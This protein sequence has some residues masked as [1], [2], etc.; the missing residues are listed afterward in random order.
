MQNATSS[1]M[2]FTVDECVLR[3]ETFVLNIHFLL[4]TSL[5]VVYCITRNA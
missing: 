5:V 4:N 2:R 3:I 1:N